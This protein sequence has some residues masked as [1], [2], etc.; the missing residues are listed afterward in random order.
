M[1]RIEEKDGWTL[2]AHQQHARLA[3][4]FAR[5]WGNAEFAPP[6]PRAD[7]LVAVARHDDAWAERDALPMLTREGRP[8]AFS[9]ELVGRYSAFE[10]IDLADYLAVRGRATEAVARDNPYAAILISMHTVN[11][12]T[13]QADLRGLPPDLL[14]LHRGFIAGQLLRQIELAALAGVVRPEDITPARLRR[15][16]E[17][18]QLCDNLSLVTCVHYPR[19]IT[20][21]HRHPA[22]DGRPAELVC[23]PLSATH[24]RV[25]P[26]PFDPDELRL[27]VPARRIAG[28]T[29]RDEAALRAAYAAAPVEQM[30]VVIVR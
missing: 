29:F 9:H 24:Y 15:A 13:E 18:L 27:A 11:L 21:R 19:P 2:V 16:F 22:R 8:G 28:A 4:Q 20:L 3:G 17:F 30:E 10:E 6:E 23:T 26:F 1:I 12:L 14:E 5:H 25:A 7:I